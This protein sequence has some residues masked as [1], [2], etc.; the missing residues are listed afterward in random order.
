MRLAPDRADAHPR[1]VDVDVAIDEEA[2][3]EPAGVVRRRRLLGGALAVAAV[4]AIAWGSGTPQVAPTRG[5]AVRAPAL[6]GA[7][8]PSLETAWRVGATVPGRVLLVASGTTLVAGPDG[9][10]GLDADGARRWGPVAAD[11]TCGPAGRGAVCLGDPAAAIALLV[12]PDGTVTSVTGPAPAADWWVQDGGVVQLEPDEGGITVR[13]WVPTGGGGPTWEAP[14]DGASAEVV[15]R[16]GTT[17]VLRGTPDRTLSLVTGREGD[18]G[19]VTPRARAWA[20]DTAGVGLVSDGDDVVVAGVGWL[21]APARLLIGGVLLVGS[22][23][24]SA[25]DLARDGEVLWARPGTAAL[26][27]GTRVALVEPAGT[28]RALVARE[29]RAGKELWRL[30]LPDACLDLAA[31]TP[32]GALLDGCGTVVAVGP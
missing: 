11:T 32:S 31:V 7:V 3:P 2:R 30:A 19:P 25:V 29:L 17:L 27:D 23:T 21:P 14:L 16:T 1:V 10:V 18:G 15:S 26:T 6:A 12:A 24:L 4:L 8:A 9:V 28:G 5:E 13:R 20:S 22:G